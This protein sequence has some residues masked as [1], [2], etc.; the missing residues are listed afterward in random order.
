MAVEHRNEPAKLIEPRDEPRGLGVSVL[1]S[2][3]M[4][5]PAD[6]EAVGEQVEKRGVVSAQLE[7]KARVPVR[8]GAE[9]T[10]RRGEACE[11][12]GERRAAYVNPRVVR[13]E[14]DVPVGPK[15]GREP[16]EERPPQ[17]AERPVAPCGHR[18][19]PDSEIAGL[20]AQQVPPVQCGRQRQA[21]VHRLDDP[22]DLS[23]AGPSRRN[24]PQLPA[25]REVTRTHDEVGAVLALAQSEPTAPGLSRVLL[26]DREASLAGYEA[27]QELSVQSHAEQM[28]A[29]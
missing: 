27:R 5:E 8:R 6:F 16:L 15:G 2:G 22:S 17:R 4:H 18:A 26:R 13:D 14:S 28:F 24:P 10:L 21:A 12:A 11:E 7:G 9:V 25:A 20:L 1:R 29:N 19:P 23:V 3:D